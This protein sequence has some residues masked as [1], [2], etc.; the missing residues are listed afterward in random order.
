MNSERDTQTI[1]E[2]FRDGQPKYQLIWS[3]NTK[4][5]L[6]HGKEVDEKTWEEEIK[7]DKK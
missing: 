7:K 2:V 4:Q 1:Y 6:I 3:N 5:F